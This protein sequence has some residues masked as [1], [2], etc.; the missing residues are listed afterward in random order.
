MSTIDDDIRDLKPMI[1]ELL[2]RSP[3]NPMG[4]SP[5]SLTRSQRDYL[6]RL[7]KERAELIRGRVDTTNA[8]TLLKTRRKMA[9]ASKR[10]KG[11]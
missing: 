3:S 4:V 8:R 11:A 7:R 10:V 1:D 6:K 2:K 9:E 5:D